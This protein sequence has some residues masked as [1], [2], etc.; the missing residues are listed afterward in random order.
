MIP[1]RNPVSYPRETIGAHLSENEAMLRQLFE[2]CFD[3]VFQRVDLSEE[4]LILMVY[5]DGL[6]DKNVFASPLFQSWVAEKA[7]AGGKGAVDY[8]VLKE[9]F[10]VVRPIRNESRVQE[11][12]ESVLRA[13]LAVFVDG[14]PEAILLETSG[15]EHRG[16]EEPANE[17]AIRGPRESFTE[18]LQINTSLVR[19]RIQTPHLKLEP[20]VLGTFSKTRIVIA[21]VEGEARPDLIGLVKQRLAGI[22]LDVVLESGYIEELIEDRT[23]S[24][25][26]Q[27]M[28]TERPDIVTA[29]LM[30]GRIAIMTDGTPQ[31]LILPIT[32]WT[33][34]QAVE[35][36]YERFIYA[37]LIRWTRFVLF[38]ISLYLPSLYVAITTFHP[39]LLPT[40]FLQNITS[41][42]EGVPFPGVIEA[43]L[44]EFLFEGLREAGVRLPKAVGSAVSIVGALVIGEAAVKAGIVSAPMVIIVSLTGIASFAIPR[45]NMSIPFRI[46]R[47]PLLL[48]SGALG[49][50]GIAMGTLLILTHMARLESFGVPYLSPIAPFQPDQIKDVLIRAPRRKI[51]SL[52][53]T[54]A[55]RPRRR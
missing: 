38:A 22:Q 21:Y 16:V 28:N 51:N 36:Y 31:V 11:I 19:R 40:N 17:V 52:K 53:A 8:P 48:S 35:D 50:F 12:V 9:H 2:H 37:T 25:F 7:G 10:A 30:E 47:F 3:V 4:C 24:P 27:M 45:Y 39:Q 5:V 1:S 13:E 32:F 26:P 18:T 33:A 42:R 44:M 6:I 20:V 15:M 43:L 34:F 41:A 14:E 54:L 55:G 23:F 29:S 46:L 49:L